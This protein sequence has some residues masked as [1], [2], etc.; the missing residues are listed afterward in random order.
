MMHGGN[1][2]LKTEIE[3]DRYLKESSSVFSRLVWHSVE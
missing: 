1:L 2:K 3:I